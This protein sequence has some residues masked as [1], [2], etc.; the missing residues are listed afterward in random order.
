M[1]N[2]R[3]ETAPSWVNADAVAVADQ[4]IIFSGSYDQAASVRNFALQRYVTATSSWET[5]AGATGS[6]RH[7]HLYRSGSRYRKC[8]PVPHHSPE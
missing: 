8:Q 7:R 4:A 5:G 6:I 1:R 2:D 3:S